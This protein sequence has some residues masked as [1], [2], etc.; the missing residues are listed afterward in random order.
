MLTSWHEMTARC[1]T[2]ATIAQWHRARHCAVSLQAGW[3]R[4]EPFASL[5]CL[6]EWGAAVLIGSS[7]WHITI[8]GTLCM[9][10][11]GYG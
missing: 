2:V 11:Y 4:E 9:Q 6:A 3:L 1:A 5:P 7:L 8:T 10:C